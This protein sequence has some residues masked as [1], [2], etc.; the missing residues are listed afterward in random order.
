[1]R[2]CLL[3][4]SFDLQGGGIARVSSEIRDELVRQGHLVHCIST[5]KES[6]PGYLSYTL[7]EM[8]SRIPKGFDVYH[9]LTPLESIW[10]PKDKGIAIILD[11]IAITHPRLYGG[12]LSKSVV[13]FHDII[14]VTHPNLQGAG[15]GYSSL[16]TSI[17]KRYFSFACNQAVKCKYVVT[18][19]EHVRE[20]VIRVFGV[21]PTRVKVIKS[22]IRED[23]EPQPKKDKKFRIGYLAQLDR[24]KRVDLLIGAFKKSDLDELVIG[25]KG[26]DEALLR[27]QAGDDPR[28]KF[29]GFIP[30]DKLVDFY[31]SLDVFVFPTAIEGYGLP[32][33]EAMA[34][35]KP[36]VVLHDSIIP[37]EVKKR[38]IIVERLDYVLG[39]QSYLQN[40]CRYTKI[41]NN[42]TWAKSHSWS[43]SVEEYVELYKEIANESI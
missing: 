29:L 2:I 13:T 19:S 11:L 12:R 14:P 30:D 9:A 23:L 39:N 36:V 42:Y 27:Q 28:I 7:L 40:L 38:C 21:E 37:W 4:R 18:V 20:E 16:K 1:M 3:T 35:R 25:G 15:V 33:V 5:K 34:C 24:R 41:D 31:N 43:K 26:L 8:P 10:I 32:I 22:G 17:A 6:L